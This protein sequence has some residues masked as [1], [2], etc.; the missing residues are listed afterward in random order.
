MKVLF[1]PFLFA[2]VL[3]IHKR[4]PILPPHVCKWCLLFS[5][6]QFKKNSLHILFLLEYFLCDWLYAMHG[7]DQTHVE[8]H[9]AM[10]L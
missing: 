2:G 5:C 3:L 1:S 6:V 8:Q 10:S 4:G 7:E 9:I